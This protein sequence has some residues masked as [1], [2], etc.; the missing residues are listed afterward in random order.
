[1]VHEEEGAHNS[2]IYQADDSKHL[3]DTIRAQQDEIERLQ[4]EVSRLRDEASLQS[5]PRAHV[6]RKLRMS[7]P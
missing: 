2:I 5:A 4:A 6:L 3:H 7:A 1:M